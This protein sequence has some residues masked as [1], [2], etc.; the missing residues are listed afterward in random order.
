M[1][2]MNEI[3][4][5]IEKSLDDV[6]EMEKFGNLKSF[7]EYCQSISEIRRLLK[8]LIRR[9]D[10]GD[11]NQELLQVLEENYKSL[12]KDSSCIEELYDSKHFKDSRMKYRTIR[13]PL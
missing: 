9:K 5:R 8:E 11:E 2:Q 3:K 4:K 1:E 7:N 10:L 13:F 12:I 6:K